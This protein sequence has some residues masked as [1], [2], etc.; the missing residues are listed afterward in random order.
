MSATVHLEDVTEDLSG[1]LVDVL[2]SVLSEEAEP[3]FEVLPTGPLAVARLAIH[4]HLAGEYTMVEVRMC[5]SLAK[6]LA[7]RMLSVARPDPDDIIDAV[8]EVGNIAGGQVKTLLCQHARLSLPSSRIQDEA[9]PE[10]DAGH[11]AAYVRAV[12]LGQIAQLAVIPGADPTGL[13][14]PPTD[15]DL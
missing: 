12:M 10:L 13:L 8:A 1:I 6:S 11:G 15:P 4:D 14:W 5:V 2:S 3:T 7:A 9:V